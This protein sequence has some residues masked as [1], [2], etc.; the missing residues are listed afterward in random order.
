MPLVPWVPKRALR[1]LADST[2][3]LSA[4]LPVFCSNVG[5]L[6]AEILRIDGTEAEYLFFRGIDR[7]VTRAALERRRGLLTVMAG[8]VGGRL[9]G[10]T[11]S[12]FD[13]TARIE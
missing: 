2:I 12:E 4:D 8:R 3:G 9:V 1:G 11:L 6:P 5:E 7:R 13:L 10:R